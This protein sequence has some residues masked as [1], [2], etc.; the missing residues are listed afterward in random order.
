MRLG[1]RG[2]GLQFLPKW[3]NPRRRRPTRLHAAAAAARFMFA[4]RSRRCSS[5]AHLLRRRLN[6]QARR[7]RRLE[8]RVQKRAQPAAAAMPRAPMVA[9]KSGKLELK[10]AKYFVY[11][12]WKR[13]CVGFRVCKRCVAILVKCDRDFCHSFARWLARLLRSS[14]LC[15][16]RFMFVSIIIVAQQQHLIVGSSVICT[17]LPSCFLFCFLCLVAAFAPS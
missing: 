16:E 17:F 5:G 4:R 8:T 11:A 9:G 7:R 3:R 12:E 14:F 13:L 15:Y 6:R 10:R 1:A 2:D